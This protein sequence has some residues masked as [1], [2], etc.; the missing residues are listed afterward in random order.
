MNKLILS[1][2]TS[3]LILGAFSATAQQMENIPIIEVIGEASKTTTPDQAT[4][5]IQLE[6]KAMNV[7]TATGVLNSKNKKPCRCT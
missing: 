4:F 1:F 5:N 7:P 2:F 6:E 3:I